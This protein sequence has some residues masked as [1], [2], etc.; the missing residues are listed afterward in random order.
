MTQINVLINWD[1]YGLWDENRITT[2][3]RL[4]IHVIGTYNYEN[5]T[6]YDGQKYYILVENDS[7]GV[8]YH[9]F[10]LWDDVGNMIGVE[11]YDTLEEGL[12]KAHRYI[13]RRI[14]GALY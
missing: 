6:K 10:E 7:N 12:I 2:V 3:G 9:P 5:R 8:P 11:M 1:S 14:K 13:E 4:K